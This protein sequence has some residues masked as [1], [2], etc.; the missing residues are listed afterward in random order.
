MVCGFYPKHIVLPQAEDVE[1]RL[2]NA[3]RSLH[4]EQDAQEAIQKAMAV[5]KDDIARQGA[6]LVDMGKQVLPAHSTD[7]LAHPP[8]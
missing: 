6:A 3:R 8:F 7:V 4:T 1:V 5:D 2:G